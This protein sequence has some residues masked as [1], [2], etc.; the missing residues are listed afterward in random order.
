MVA[1][2]GELAEF[3]FLLFLKEKNICPKK[4]KLTKRAF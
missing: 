4:K 2:S 3:N 1:M